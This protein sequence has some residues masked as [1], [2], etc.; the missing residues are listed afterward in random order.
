MGRGLLLKDAHSKEKGVFGDL[1]SLS[2]F[3][4]LSQSYNR[5]RRWSKSLDFE[6]IAT[7]SH[8]Y[9]RNNTTERTLPAWKYCHIKP[10][11]NFEAR[12]LLQSWAWACC[13]RCRRCSEHVQEGGG[14]SGTCSC[15]RPTNSSNL[16]IESCARINMGRGL[17]LK[18]VH[19]KEKGV[20]GDLSS[21]SDFSELSQ[22]H[23]RCRKRSKL[24]DFEVME[25]RSRKL[26]PSNQVLQS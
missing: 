13:T 24:L 8:M 19:S 16:D 15:Y 10:D 17:L 6:V 2:D 12:N 9:Q 25:H 20:F 5:C 26:L 21:L 14:S 11:T 23:N 4:E 3:S 18:D 7:S 22:S 1:S